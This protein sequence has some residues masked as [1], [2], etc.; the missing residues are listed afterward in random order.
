MNGALRGYQ[1][2]V[3]DCVLLNQGQNY[4][5]VAPTASGKTRIPIE[6]A[7]ALLQRKPSAKILFLSPTVALT[8]QQTGPH[9]DLHECMLCLDESTMNP[10]WQHNLQLYRRPSGLAMPC[11]ARPSVS[12]WYQCNSARC[13][14]NSPANGCIHCDTLCECL[15]GVSHQSTAVDNE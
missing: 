12:Q 3:L 13:A 6:V 4:I 11:C 9:A 7:G 14:Q 5:I 15:I 10:L 8:E 2:R 1:Q